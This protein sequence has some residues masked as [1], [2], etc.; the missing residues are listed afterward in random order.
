MVTIESAIDAAVSK[1]VSYLKQ[2]QFPNGEFCCY[3]GHEDSMKDTVPDA[4]NFPTSLIC[5]SLLKLAYL[6]EV[7]QIL[8]LSASFLQFQSMRAGVWN[9]FTMAHKYFKICPAD[10]DNTAC[11]SIF[12]RAFKRE[13]VANEE[14]LLCNRAKSG[15]FYTWYTFRPNTVWNKDYWILLL[16]EFRFPLSTYLFWTKNEPEKNDIDGAVNANVLFYLGEKESTA[17]IINYMI[18]IIADQ[19]ENDCDKW[20]RNP[21]TIYY[22]FSRAFHSGIPSLEPVKNPIIQRI[23]DN[24]N[25]NGSLGK[26][27]L[28]TALGIIS[29]IK[30]DYQGRILKDAVQYLLTSQQQYGEWPR[31]GLY[32]GGPKQDQCYGSEEITTGFCLEALALYKIQLQDSE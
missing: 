14:I 13:Y 30:L 29:L 17:P 18:N 32:Y 19:K 3:I 2:H 9:N 21:F 27:V 16:R 23:I 10:V 8:Q 15:L 22:F 26:S 25:E 7:T 5:Y 11:A 28:D 20:Y 1:G 6:P 4:N 12:L 24:A 31:W